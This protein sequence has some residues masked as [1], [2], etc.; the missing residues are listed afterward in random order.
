[1][2]LTDDDIVLVEPERLGD[3]PDAGGPISGRLIVS[4]KENNLFPDI[5]PTDRVRG[6]VKM[7]KSFLAVRGTGAEAL[8]GALIYI[9]ARPKD[10]R[11]AVT[12]FGTPDSGDRRRH[13]RD[14]VERYLARGTRWAGQLLERQLEGQKTIAIVQRE[15][16]PLPRVG[17]VLCLVE[18]EGK[19][20]EYEQY[21][22]VVKTRDEIREFSVNIGGNQPYTFRRRVVTCEISDPLRRDFTG[23]SPSPFDDG[24]AAAAVRET[25]VANAAK[26]YGATGL[27][28]AG[29]PGEFSIRVESI[30]S[31]LVPSAQTETV[32]SQLSAAGQGVALFDAGA[33]PVTITVATTVAPGA[34][35]HVGSPITPGSLSIKFGAVLM[36]DNGGRLML[37]GAEV[38]AVDY[39]GGRV[40]F[41]VDCPIWRGD[42]LVTFQPGAASSRVTNTWATPVTVESRSQN[43]IITLVPAPAPGTLVVSYR[44]GERWVD[45]RDDGSGG[46]RAAEPSLGAGR[47]DYASGTATIT[48]GALPDADT[49]IL[50]A[51]CSRVA[52]FNRSNTP[53]VVGVQLQ[54]QLPADK[55]LTPKTVR[56]EWDTPNG[57]AAASDNGSGMLTG[58]AVGRLDYASGRI[59]M[60]P[61]TLPATGQAYRIVSSSAA[62]PPKIYQP[63]VV[64]DT[65][66]PVAFVLPDE[67]VRGTL[68]LPVVY[69]RNG[70]PYEIRLV[71]N[72]VGQ[73]VDPQGRDVGQ[74]DYATKT[75]SF[76]RYREFPDVQ[77]GLFTANNQPPTAVVIEVGSPQFK[78]SSVGAATYQVG[79]S[80]PPTVIDATATE[81]A[82]DLTF[83]DQERI[84][85]GSVRFRLGG[86]VYIDRVGSLYCDIDPATGSGIHAGTIDYST[87]RCVL[88]VWTAGAPTAPATE[89]LATAMG[90]LLVGGVCFRTPVA[91]IRPGSLNVIIDV[92]G[93][94][95]VSVQAE[96]S[97]KITGAG[98][99]GDFEAQTGIVRLRFGDYVLAAGNEGEWWY[100]P[101]LVRGDGK[102]FKPRLYD[103]VGIRY[104]AVAY[105]YLPLSAELLGLDPVRLP[106]DGRV[107]IIRPGD[108]V[109]IH[110][111]ASKAVPAPTPGLK[112]GVGRTRLAEVRVVDALG[113]E[114][115]RSMYTADLDPGTV[116]LAAPLDLT[117]FTLPLAVEHRVEDQILCNDAQISGDIGLM[118]PLTHDYPAGETVVSSCMEVGDLFARASPPFSQQTWTGEWADSRVGN[119]INAQYQSTVYPIVVNN[120]GAIDQRWALVFSSNTA[121]K[122][123]GEGVGEIGAGTTSSDCAPINPATG[124]P[125][126]TIKAAGWGGGWP[127]GAVLRFNTR[128]AYAA[129]WIARSVQMGPATG[130]ADSF[131]LRGF[132][133]VD[134]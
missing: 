12:L 6:G 58:D 93:G 113:K 91:P 61:A 80:T 85:P 57:M 10:P 132:G 76:A 99:E 74:I 49:A 7:A 20:T 42:K 51:W 111:T 78:L 84:V 121:F 73:L 38:G 129:A 18:N 72:G 45:L 37:A 123:I 33:G 2:S 96:T 30:F 36:T 103:P 77:F 8:A 15:S 92:P 106:S 27:T 95:T 120:I 88:S 131:R 89:S 9:S 133:G 104:N 83:N 54:L 56:I 109:A 118:R 35:M 59:V 119:P 98:F 14:R 13:A 43:A 48:M 114:L 41:N 101:D 65:G 97:G 19:P 115:P 11:V 105:T 87:G 39:P 4:G 3:D 23:P 127:I 100:K 67:W 110:H 116:T 68:R 94:G 62:I 75:V 25:V 69:A 128:G 32:L 1:M 63:G 5:S 47:I 31:Q 122:V 29:K 52:L 53:L 134:A 17:M 125:Y 16:A 108:I 44:T 28:R 70:K 40:T 81:L 79:S 86:R 50:Y 107:P 126:F 71:D 21:V 46:L 26:Y 22:R 64:P 112:I 34:A 82:V 130:G 117:G 66:D 124:K 55:P 90:G 24:N 60:A 102:I